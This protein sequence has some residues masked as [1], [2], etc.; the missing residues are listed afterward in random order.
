MTA[1]PARERIAPAYTRA[2]LVRDADAPGQPGDPIRFLAATEG[3]KGDG[4]DLRMSGARLE[5]YLAN[6][7][8]GYN[9]QYWGRDGLPIGRGEGTAVVGSQLFIDVVFDQD[10]DFAKRVEAKYRNGFLNAVSIGFSVWAWEDGKGSY[11]L[12]GVAQEWELTELSCVPVP[13]DPEAV[14]QG[15]RSA[16]ARA[17]EDPA[18]DAAIVD[19][20]I[21]PDA[22]GRQLVVRV[23]QE[24]AAAADPMALAVSI[25]RAFQR[26]EDVPPVDQVD[27]DETPEA[28]EGQA[29][30]DETEPERAAPPALVDNQAAQDLLA[31][32]NSGGPK[33]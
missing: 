11:W 33:S 4:I 26:T 29:P 2:Y 9:H 27:E 30:V 12:G 24:L 13:M 21:T 28:D 7:V 5:R 16:W 17:L 6:P 10:D 18:L 19:V 1:P 3:Q 22:R 25:A 8:V 31:A 15:G 14:A 23:S 20:E 32:F